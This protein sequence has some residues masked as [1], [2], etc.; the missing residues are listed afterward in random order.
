M[1]PWKYDTY[2]EFVVVARNEEDAINLVNEHGWETHSIPEIKCN[3]IG[4]AARYLKRGI[5]VECFNA[6]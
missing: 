1:P 4:T 2:T 6:G 5:L 3:Y